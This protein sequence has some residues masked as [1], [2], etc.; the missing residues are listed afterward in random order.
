MAYEIWSGMLVFNVVV[1]CV[2][3]RIYVIS[4]QISP[5]LVIA[6]ILS[7]LSYYL[8]F[9]LVEVMIYSDCKNL[10]NHQLA[11]GMFWLLVIIL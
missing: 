10:L 9:F 2:N 3:V 7:V 11:S 4:S 5:I 8:I 1:V 6:S